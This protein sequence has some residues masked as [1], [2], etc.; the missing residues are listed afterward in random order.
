MQYNTPQ[1]ER[2]T[3]T[4]AATPGT[5]RPRKDYAPKKRKSQ[6]MSVLP[7]LLLF[8]ALLAAMY[9]LF[10]KQAGRHIG[11]SRYDGLVIS[12]VMAS[13]ASAVPDENGEFSDWLELY[14]GTGQDLDMEGVMLTNRTDRITFPFPSYTLK[15]GE[16]VIV[17]A[18][19]SYQ[20]DPSLPFHGKFKI[21]SAGDHIYLYDPDMYLIDELATPTLTADT[22][23]ALTGVDEDG[24]RHYETTTFYS[25]GY[26][27]TEEGFSQYRSANATQSGALVIN[28]VCPDPRIGIP[29]EDG[30]IVDW[31]ELKN[32]T[33]KPISLSGYYLSDKENKPMKWRFPE[34]ATIPANGYYLVYCSGKNKLQ[35]NGV[36]HTSFSLSAERE[37][38]VLSDSYGRLVDRVSFENVPEDYS[39]GRSDVGDW[40][41]F[42]LSTPGQPNNA[43]GQARS[44]E[45]FRAYNSTGVIIS[46]VMA[47]NSTVALGATGA[48]T[49]YVELYNTSAQ[50]VDLTGYGLSDSLK[51]PRRWQFPQGTTIAPGEYKIVYLDGQ[52]QLTTVTDCHTNFKLRRAG[53]ETI[54]FCDPTGRV[55]DRIPLSLIP[56]DHSYG[57]T[58][59]YS[60]FYYY[61]VPTPG[62]ANGTGYYGYAKTPAVSIPGGE[63][64]G[65]IQVSLTVPENTAVYY[66]LDGSIPT[67][68]NGVRYASGETLAIS[69]VTVLRAR[70]FDQSGLLQPSEIVTQT[71]LMNLYHAFPIVSLVTDPDELWNEESGMLAIGGELVKEPGKL[72]FKLA[73]GE[74][75]LYRTVGKIARPGHVEYYDK[76]GNTLIDQ[77]C[78][79]GL[80]G[81]YS[82]DMPQK[83]FK[84]RA[85]AKYGSKY[86]ESKLFEDLDFTQYKSFVL[87]MGG[88]D[89]VWTRFNDAFQSQLIK[90]FNQITDTPSTVIYQEWQPVVVYLNG[91]YWGHYNMRE[92]VDRYFV[93]QHE[94]L[95]L[96][97][98][99]NMDLLEASGTVNYGSNKE[100]KAMI[101]KI[102]K[103]SPGTKEEDL[104][105]ILDNIDV[106][107]YFDYM[108]FEMFFGNSDPG[109]IRF[110]KLDKEGS[111]WRWIFY[112][113]DYG[114]FRSGFDSPTSYLKESGAG[115]KKINNTLIRKLLEN[116][117]MRDKFLTRL[118][119]IYQV[120]TTE[121]MTE[122]FNEMAATLEPEMTM[123]F[124]RWAEEN[125]KNINSDSPTTPEGAIRYWNTRLDYTRNVLKKRPTYFYEMVQER[126]E[127][128]DEQML[129][130][131]GEKP[132]LPDDATV[133]EGRK[134]G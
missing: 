72:P 23:Y 75:P 54:S 34:G 100:Y 95:P 79:F 42:E 31:V 20:L 123:H 21:S 86:F 1:Q 94:G 7:L 119:E 38:F 36:P 39:Y 73:S 27:N 9:F 99:D 69:R 28:E 33:D 13:N 15:A 47:S 130:Y 59:G 26:E 105:Y 104:Q 74:Y 92:R 53:G 107:N 129:D 81:Q 45:M 83:T 64:K 115:D 22:S 5:R 11:A 48:T 52:A 97:E 35:A 60:G 6:A 70:A 25:P 90:R 98:A 66:T 63:Y 40:R 44:D 76:E 30:E 2:R 131:F 113:S 18:T 57:R 125:D 68:E 108:A 102:E 85:K 110:Y 127:L 87:R 89:C 88:N 96:G 67:E 84:V 19:N 77:D 126:F 17:F 51:R 132:P 55:L 58:L 50:T 82:L 80:Q 14:N 16:R 121:F 134:W 46:E 118:G 3:R 78:E 128:T 32:N 43:S 8:V 122:L 111:K 56:T 41:L 103:S 4:D 29:D 109:N 116:D 101:S 114:L 91:V 12:E 37:S 24:V 112:D 71:Y 120:F 10:P 62:T 124:N 49:D 117:E 106:D 93:A 133:T 61:D 65:E